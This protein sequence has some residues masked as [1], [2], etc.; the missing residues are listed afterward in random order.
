MMAEIWK[1]ERAVQRLALHR[2]C[3]KKKVSNT[4]N[5]QI[6]EAAD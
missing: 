4:Q 2:W 1:A 6:K 3:R 5:T